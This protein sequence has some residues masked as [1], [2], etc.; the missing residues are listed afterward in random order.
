MRH[1]HLVQAQVR[2]GVLRRVDDASPAIDRVRDEPTSIRPN[3]EDFP[4][5][6]LKC[7]SF[8]FIVSNVNHTLSVVVIVRPSGC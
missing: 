4:T 5:S 1:P 6:A 7:D 2:E 8:V 3:S